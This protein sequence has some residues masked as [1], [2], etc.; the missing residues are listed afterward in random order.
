MYMINID[1]GVTSGKRTEKRPDRGEEVL[2]AVAR[3]DCSR[4]GWVERS[5][6]SDMRVC[7]TSFFILSRSTDRALNRLS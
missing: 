7:I 4:Y 6:R 1:G 3:G 5:D 2:L